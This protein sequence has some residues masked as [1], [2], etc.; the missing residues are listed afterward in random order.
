MVANL[1][2][3]DLNGIGHYQK[4]LFNRAI[5]GYI[6]NSNN[7]SYQYKRKGILSEIPHLRLLKGALVVRKRDVSKIKP[8]FKKFNIKY[9]LYEIL[10]DESKLKKE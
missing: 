6:D 4:V 2:I 1:I 8:I 9:T 3:H 5:Y 7:N 10:I